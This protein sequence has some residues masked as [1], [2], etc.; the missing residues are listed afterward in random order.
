MLNVGNLLNKR[1][2][3]IDEISFN[4]V[5]GERRTLV[6]FVGLDSQGRY[7]Y[8]V[9]SAA[10]DLTTRQQ[11]GESQWAMQATIRYEF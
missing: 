7:V 4:A 8:S 5:G 3:R 6:N 11:R 9:K 2:G 1:W 10:D